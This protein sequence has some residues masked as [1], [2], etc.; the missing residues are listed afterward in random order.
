MLSRIAFSKK[1]LIFLSYFC[2]IILVEWDMSDNT[3]RNVPLYLCGSFLCYGDSKHPD[4]N[5]E[6]NITNLII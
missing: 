5:T 1:H 6:T 2:M 4:M 3:V